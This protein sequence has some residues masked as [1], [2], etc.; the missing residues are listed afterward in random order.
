MWKC[1]SK[2]PLPQTSIGISSPLPYFI[3]SHLLICSSLPP[4]CLLSHMYRCRSVHNTLTRE[5]R[6]RD[7][8]LDG[9]CPRGCRC[10][11]EQTVS[12]PPQNCS[13]LW[14]NTYIMYFIEAWCEYTYMYMDV[15]HLHV[16]I[17]SFF[18][19]QWFVLLL[20]KKGH[21]LNFH[22]AILSYPHT[23]ADWCH[24]EWRRQQRC[25]VHHWPAPGGSWRGC[26]RP[27]VLATH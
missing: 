6:L 10:N 14:R 7:L 24:S 8:C 22:T 23:W 26:T 15:L 27:P 18:W 20:Y 4:E 19:Y 5:G 21:S 2:F 25:Q 16:L 17:K 11:P 1:G 3:S 9:S 13:M 12:F